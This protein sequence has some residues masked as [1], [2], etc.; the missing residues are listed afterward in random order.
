MFMF[1]VLYK[2]N[3]GILYNTKRKTIL[4]KIEQCEGV[5]IRRSIGGY[6]AKEAKFCKR[7]SKHLVT[8]LSTKNMYSI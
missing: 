1:D 8:K 4:R 3:W 6:F 7:K 5:V 2:G